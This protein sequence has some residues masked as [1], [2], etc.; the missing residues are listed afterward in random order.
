MTIWLTVVTLLCCSTPELIPPI[1]NFISIGQYFPILP[2]SL[3]S[4]VTIGYRYSTLYFY[5]I[6][7]RY[8]IWAWS[9]SISFC[10]WFISLNVTSSWLICVVTNDRISFF[11]LHSILL[12]ICTTFSGSIHLSVEHFGWRVTHFLASFDMCLIRANAFYDY[13][14]ETTTNGQMSRWITH[15]F[16]VSI[17]ISSP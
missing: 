1:H 14:K 12:C 6:N 5:N 4:P 3:L 2:F 10:A 11:W 13:S 16:N 9:C 7:F 8:K 15:S 17:C